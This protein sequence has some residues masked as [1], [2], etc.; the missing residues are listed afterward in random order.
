MLETIFAVVTVLLGAVF[1]LLY[2]ERTTSAKHAPLLRAKLDMETQNVVAK[3]RH[4]WSASLHF[5]EHNILLKGLHMVTYLA[6]VNV[7]FMERKLMSLSQKLRSF[8]KDHHVLR[9]STHKLTQWT[10]EHR[11]GEER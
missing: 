10:E 8:R 6:L 7:R 4:A 1:A 5:V 2:K 11:E 9:R 3:A